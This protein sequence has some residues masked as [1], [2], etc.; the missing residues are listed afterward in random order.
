MVVFPFS[1]LFENEIMVWTWRFFFAEKKIKFQVGP[2]YA[3]GPDWQSVFAFRRNWVNLTFT[4]KGLVTCD[5]IKC[6]E[7]SNIQEAVCVSLVIRVIIRWGRCVQP[8][9]SILFFLRYIA[10]KPSPS[11]KNRDRETGLTHTSS[12]H[13]HTFSKRIIKRARRL[14]ILFALLRERFWNDQG[15]H[16]RQSFNWNTLI[17]HKLI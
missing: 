13:T 14:E 11:L 16:T 6:K 3:P 5:F 12:T 7:V 2:L 17:Y 4:S 8:L 10:Q 15:E 9:F 1:V